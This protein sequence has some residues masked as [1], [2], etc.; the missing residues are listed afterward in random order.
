MLVEYAREPGAKPS[1]QII[2][3]GFKTSVAQAAYVN[4]RHRDAGPPGHVRHRRVR[5]GFTGISLV[6]TAA[7]A[8]TGGR[9]FGLDTDQLQYAGIDGARPYDESKL[10]G[11][12]GETW[13]VELAKIAPNR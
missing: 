7:A 11:G 13:F 10:I 8:V 4:G 2:G 6:G 1:A 9:L 3:G 12:L 5:R